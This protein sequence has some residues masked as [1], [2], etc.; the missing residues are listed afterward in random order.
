MVQGISDGCSWFPELWLYDCC[1]AHDLGA[2]DPAFLTCIADHSQFMG[3]VGY[4]FAGAVVCGMCI[5]RPVYHWF[6]RRKEK[7]GTKNDV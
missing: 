1:V 3:P 2:G 4:L 7:K 5:G 6:K